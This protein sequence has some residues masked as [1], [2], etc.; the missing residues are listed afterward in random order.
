MV[1]VATLISYS[2]ECQKGH[3]SVVG[4]PDSHA[5]DCREFGEGKK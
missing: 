5:V 1:A 2:K 3:C 4:F